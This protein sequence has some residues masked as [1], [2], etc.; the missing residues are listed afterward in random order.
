MIRGVDIS[1]YQALSNWEQ[2]KESGIA[3]CFL[4]C[5]EGLQLRDS[6]FAMF[7]ADCQKYG[8]P[9]GA[10]HFFHPANDPILQAKFFLNTV[11]VEGG[12]L[13][14]VMDWETKGSTVAHDDSVALQF[15]EYVQTATGKT[16]MIYGSPAFLNE[17]TLSPAFAKY[18]LW[19]AHYGVSHP[20]V[21]RP[22][23]TWTYWQFS[24]SAKIPGV[25]GNCD[26]NYFSLVELNS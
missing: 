10:Y 19:V 23:T 1:H 13:P 15:L 6:K 25:I 22:W 12:T 7:S 26:E 21:P 17:R 4:K 14:M 8:I 16:P 24:G 18:P 5:T 9:H 3:F 11:G 2:M 20:T